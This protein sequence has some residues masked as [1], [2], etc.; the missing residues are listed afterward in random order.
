MHRIW[1][2]ETGDPDSFWHQTQRSFVNVLEAGAARRQREIERDLTLAWQ[3]GNFAQAKLKRL[4]YY[5]KK[6]RPPK[7]QS[8][9]EMVATFKAIN[10]DSNLMNIRYLN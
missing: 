2:E 7:P 1:I 9:A 5:L 8:A 10:G 6:M 4:D 3:T